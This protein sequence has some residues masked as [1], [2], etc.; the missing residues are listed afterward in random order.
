MDLNP[1]GRTEFARVER[2]VDASRQGIR[3]QEALVG[4]FP[5]LLPS[6]KSCKKA[7][8]KGR[9]LLH[10]KPADTAR[11]VQGGDVVTF[12]PQTFQKAPHPGPGAPAQ[13]RMIRPENADYLLA[14]K[15]AGLATSGAGRLHLANV[16]AHLS[17]EGSPEQRAQLRPIVNDALEFPAPVHRLDRVTAGW[18]CIALN[19]NAAQSLGQAFAEQR[20]QKRYLALVAGRVLE[21]GDCSVS[22]DGKSAA[23]KWSP[24]CSGPLPVHGTATLLDVQPKTGRT[25]QIRRHLAHVEHPIVGEHLYPKEHEEAVE[26]LERYTGHGLFLSAVGMHIPE[27]DHG[28]A[29]T[30]SS[31]P[32]R[33]FSRITWVSRGVESLSL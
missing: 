9:I 23:T 20:I 27:G 19:L 13:L 4:M 1:Q 5:V 7:I 14:W 3:L 18:V 15:P 2:T 29:I 32:P 30:V 28:P 16:L 12:L 31:P 8:E 6:R 11:I 21:A 26:P 24:V 33:K 17:S 22:L 10:G 25:H